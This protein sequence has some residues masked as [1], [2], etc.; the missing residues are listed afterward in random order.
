M[1]P[2]NTPNSTLTYYFDIC[3]AINQWNQYIN[4]LSRSL[5]KNTD[6]LIY[7]SDILIYW[8]IDLFII[9]YWLF[10]IYYCYWLLVYLFIIHLFIYWYTDLFLI[11]WFIFLIYWLDWLKL[12]GA[13]LCWTHVRFDEQYYHSNRCPVAYY[14]YGCLATVAKVKVTLA[15]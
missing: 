13:I 7:I 5:N 4:F 8:F 3:Q 12:C 9:Y 14:Q 2:Y 11:Y 10:I 6:I 1:F 15:P